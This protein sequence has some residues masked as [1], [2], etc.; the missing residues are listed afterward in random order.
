MAVGADQMA[1]YPQ[2]VKP[3]RLLLI[4]DEADTLSPVL[5][6]GLEPLGFSLIKENDPANALQAVE[7]CAPDAILLD[8]HFPGDDETGE[9][10]TTGGR[11][12]TQFRR[13]FGS[14]PVLVF[15]MRLDDVDVPLETF[16]ERPHGFFAKPEFD[17]QDEWADH[18][19][20]AVRD[21]IA[22][23]QH[24]EVSE[25]EDLGFLVGQTR[26]MHE[27]AA[28]IRTA[29]GNRLAVLIYGETGTG[30]RR[31]AEAVHRLSGRTG[32]FEHYDCSGADLGT[33]QEAL[34]GGKLTVASASGGLFKLADQGTLLLDE[35][36]GLPVALQDR[37]VEAV[38]RGRPRR[39][40]AASDEAV[41][42]RLIVSTNHSLSDLV[43]DGVLRRDLAYRLAEGLPVSLPPLRQ[44]MVD[45]PVLFARLVERANEET[46]R[47]GVSTVL[48]P[49]TRKKLEAHAWPG[50]IRELKSTLV[51]AVA[52]TNSNV[53]L[54]DDIAFVAIAPPGSDSSEHGDQSAAPLPSARA[55]A[56]DTIEPAVAAVTNHL[57]SLPIPERYEYLRSQGGSLRRGVL[58]EFV[59]RLRAKTGKRIQ[60]KVLAAELDP[61][62][63]PERDL[64]RIRQFLH[65][66]SIQLTRLDCNR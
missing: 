40:G 9:P 61:L 36:Q 35:I 65:S 56:L 24:A 59:R 54:P 55:G 18:L 23:V 47:G 20:R 16:E 28:A 66:N 58:V 63:D 29:A 30:R 13:R 1:A 32:R 51:R 49:E 3:I 41:D 17:R 37:V 7:A 12:L 25:D 44:R 57:E 14:V 43:A 46:Q 26:E 6:Q 60:H 22:A 27:A 19:A 11:L 39:A 8:L 50:N 15:T 5:A 2:P 52:T 45:L 4:D 64:N 53:L 33:A 21:A 34:F 48:R 38:E 31:A 10:G 42:V 62:E